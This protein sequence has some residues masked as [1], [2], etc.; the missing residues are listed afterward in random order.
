M[1]L[2]KSALL[3]TALAFNSYADNHL[4]SGQ[5]WINHATLGLAPYWMMPTAQGEPV[6]NFP[7]FRCDDGTL[8]DVNNVCPELDRGWI[9]PNFDRDYTRMKSRQTYA[10]GVL[11]HM[12][13][14]PKA[15]TLAKQGAY[16]LIN[17]L[18]DKEN[19][20]FISFTKQGVPGL[21]WKQRTSQDQAYALVGLAMYYYLTQDKN[22]ERA[23][24]EQQAFIFDKYRLADDQGLAWVLED[25]DGESARQRELVAQLDQINGYL[26]L[27]APLLPEPA[28]SKWLADLSWLTQVLVSHYHSDQ[29]QRFYGAIHHKAVMM[30]DA[31]HNDFGHTIKAYW[32]TY[33]TGQTLG[34]TQWKEFGFNGMKQTLQQAKNTRNFSSVAYL[35]DEPLTT[36]WQRE[37][38]IAWRSR[39]YTDACSSWE[40]AELD[41]AA[42]T[43]SMVDNSMNDVLE[44]TLPTYH[45]AW[46]DH[47]YGG[48][49]LDPKSTKAF[50]WGNGYHQF[51][52][53]LVGYLFAQQVSRQA[54]QLYYARPKN[55]TLAFAPY[56]YRGEVKKVTSLSGE[57]IQQVSFEEIRP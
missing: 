13:G 11:F 40:W 51:E 1:K 31:K 46:V 29:E 26:L 57:K 15:L 12:S 8:L 25:G 56:Y 38:I 18:Q 36:H 3:L 20:G 43:V 49:G 50:H 17:H 30:A 44:F 28:K 14:D 39:P 27:V 54:A 37:D 10:Y 24:I 45:D 47:K 7:T 16:Y 41:Q 2:H 5:D 22:V 19:G 48:V 53:A 32:M 21:N 34:N 23:L 9:R 35:F 55:S 52:H 6:G 33:L 42:M 4:P